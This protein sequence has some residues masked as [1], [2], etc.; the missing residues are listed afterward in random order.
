MVDG[1][2]I[3][4]LC[5]GGMQVIRQR[6]PTAKGV[7]FVLLED[8]TGV[9]DVVLQPRVAERYRHMLRDEPLILVQGVIQ[10]GSG[11]ISLLASRVTPL[12]VG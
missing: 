6:P 11:A 9:L 2:A 10:T 5:V 4:D 7:M 12:V 3:D 8:E 1:C